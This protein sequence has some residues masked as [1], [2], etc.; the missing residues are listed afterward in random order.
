VADVSLDDFGVDHQ[1]LGDVLQGAEDDVR[2]QE[3]L[4]QR[5]PPAHVRGGEMSKRVE[6]AREREASA[7]TAVGRHIS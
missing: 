6:A 7:R 4:G 5:D 2:R 1:A 3:R